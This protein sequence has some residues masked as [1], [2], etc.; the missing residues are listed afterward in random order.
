MAP[1]Y[2]LTYFNLRARGE[3]SRLVLAAGGVPFED[4]RIER[5]AW[6]ELKPNT[7]MG[8]M[9]LLEVDGQVVCQSGA[10]ARYLARETGLGGKS[11]WEEAQVDMFVCGVDD[12]ITEFCDA[13]FAPDEATK[14]E[15][16]KALGPYVTKFLG[17]YEKLSGSEGHLV[18]SSL[19]YADL[20]FFV[21]MHDVLKHSAGAL[22][23]YPKLAKVVES[24]KENKGVAAYIAERPESDI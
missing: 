24:V 17:N 4:Y 11:S 14:E 22:E 12:L 19:T 15:R 7:P 5:P 18:G 9:P 8:Q 23:K 16:T 3:L 2:K 20:A 1:K 21:G 10:I 6:A 13:F